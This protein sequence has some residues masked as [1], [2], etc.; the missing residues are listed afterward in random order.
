VDPTET[1]LKLVNTLAE[2]E[3]E[4]EEDPKNPNTARL[5]K[6]AVELLDSLSEWLGRLGGFPP[7]LSE[8]DLGEGEDEN[9]DGDDVIDADFGEE[10]DD[11]GVDDGD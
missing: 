10:D 8:L 2:L 4:H 9:E 5:R 1:F 6:E 3:A 7:K 11:L